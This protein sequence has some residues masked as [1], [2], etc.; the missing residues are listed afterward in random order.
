[1]SKP[2]TDDQEQAL[3]TMFSQAISQALP[4]ILSQIPQSQPQTPISTPKVKSLFTEY[5]EFRKD[6]QKEAVDGNLDVEISGLIG[7]STFSVLKSLEGKLV[8]QKVSTVGHLM[9]AMRG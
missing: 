5:L 3:K 1:M 2:F 6:V 8:D 9:R 4:S 7:V